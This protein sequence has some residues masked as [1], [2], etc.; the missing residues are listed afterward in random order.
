MN[1]AWK[2]LTL[3]AGAAAG[4][5]AKMAVDVIWE[6]G[7]GKRKP[8]GDD[9]DLDQSFAQVVAFTAVTTIVATIATEAVRRGAAKAYGK[10]TAPQPAHNESRA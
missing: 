1:I 4:L 7:L 3:G 6:K 2:A 8:A 9:S 10:R 5:V